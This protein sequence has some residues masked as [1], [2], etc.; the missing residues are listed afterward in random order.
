LFSGT[1][2]SVWGY[3]LLCKQCVFVAAYTVCNKYG[4]YCM[5]YGY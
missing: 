3:N 5:G 1:I 2:R 4:C